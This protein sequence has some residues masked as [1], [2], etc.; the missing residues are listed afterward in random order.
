MPPPERPAP[1][2]RTARHGPD[3]EGRPGYSRTTSV[4]RTTA[5]PGLLRGRQVDL[6][7]D[8]PVV[9]ARRVVDGLLDAPDTGCRGIRLIDLDE[10]RRPRRSAREDLVVLV[11]VGVE[12]GRPVDIGVE[13]GELVVVLQ[14]GELDAAE[15]LV[16][17]QHAGTRGGS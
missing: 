16:A 7:A 11:E 13:R 1:G 2:N 17:H 3:G 15:Q 6:G 4:T 8:P 9:V 10:S 5:V 14:R 12:R